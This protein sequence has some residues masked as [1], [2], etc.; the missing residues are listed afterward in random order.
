MPFEI[1]M[2]P[3]RGAVPP[4]LRALGIAEYRQ[5]FFKPYSPH[6]RVVIYVTADGG[7][8]MQSLLAR[9]RLGG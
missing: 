3:E 7:R 6:E 8:D 4:E 5:V 1:P 9:R 2:L